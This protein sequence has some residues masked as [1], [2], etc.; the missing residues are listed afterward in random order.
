MKSSMDMVKEAEAQI[1]TWPVEEAI[2][3]VGD[4]DVVFV[5][6]RDVRELWR[7][8][9]VPGST[10]APRGML[11]FWVDP[12]SPYARPVFQEKKRFVFFCA[13]GWRSALATK[14]MQDMGLTPVCHI[15]GGF[16][17]WQ[18]AGGPVAKVEKK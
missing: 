10:H 4:P 3:H 7:E 13:A 14:E 17:A 11:E 18:K 15:E 9:T 8:G 16:G 2:K 12:A 6:L 5:D 1:E